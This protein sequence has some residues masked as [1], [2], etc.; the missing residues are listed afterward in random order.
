[1][2]STPVSILCH[3]GP[4]ASGEIDGAWRQD[5]AFAAS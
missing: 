4:H 5:P 1:M 3:V 2:S